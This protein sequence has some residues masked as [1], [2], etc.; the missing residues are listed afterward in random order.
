MELGITTVD[1]AISQ[2]NNYTH[3]LLGNGIIADVFDEYGWQ[4]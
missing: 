2:I 3:F 4:N 1:K